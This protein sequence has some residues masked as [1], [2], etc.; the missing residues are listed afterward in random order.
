VGNIPWDATE[1]EVMANC[2]AA[3]GRVLSFELKRPHGAALTTPH[4]PRSV[5]ARRKSSRN[6]AH[7]GFGFME[8]ENEEAAASAIRKHRRFPIVC[9]NRCLRIAYP[10]NNA[11]NRKEFMNIGHRNDRII[12]RK[13]RDWNNNN[14]RRR[15]KKNSSSRSCIP[16]LSG[17]SLEDQ[18]IKAVHEQQLMNLKMKKRPHSDCRT[19]TYSMEADDGQQPVHH[20]LQEDVRHHRHPKK[21]FVES[22]TISSTTATRTTEA[23]QFESDLLKIIRMLS[24][25]RIHDSP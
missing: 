5:A 19:T 25:T 18:P 22:R 12:E 4:E 13:I 17:N 1:E 24:C 11:M 9:R 16:A 6:V 14:N 8:F 2:A 23:D 21:M 10:A 7:R 15:K 3:L 20:H